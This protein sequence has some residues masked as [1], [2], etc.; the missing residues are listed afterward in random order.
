VL[1][2]DT[3]PHFD[4]LRIVLVETSHPGNIGATARAMKNMGLSRLVLVK[5]QQKAWPAR[6]A[7]AMAAS[8]LDVLDGVVVTATL[9]EAIAG[10]HLVIGTSARL[11]NMPVQLL[12]PP[13]A[14]L[15]IAGVRSTQEVALVFGREISGLS[16]EE[17]HLCHYHVHIP[18]NPDYTSLNLAAAVMV[19]AYEVRKA[20]L[21]AGPAAEVPAPDWDQIPATAEEL[22]RY[23]AHLE[24]VL[25][26][27]DFLDPD[28]PRQ[29]LRRLRR[30]YQR[31]QPD[32]MEVNILR[33][34]LSATETALTKR[35]K[36]NT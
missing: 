19:L 33:G 21:A 7:L 26:Q 1:A 12:D 20:A 30:L 34:I 15:R 6:E 23:L 8:A 5:P 29:L 31:I 3:N 2:P 27:I 16:N 28:N 25:I 14:A 9:E 22:E 17:L 4:K 18:V 36:G 10:C 24:K 35:E 32:R 13:A 11:R